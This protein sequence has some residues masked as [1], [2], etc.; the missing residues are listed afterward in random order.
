MKI[1]DF[2]E[3]DNAIQR[4]IELVYVN[5]LIKR[6]PKKTG[7]TA[8]QWTSYSTNNFNYVISNTEGDIIT[9]LE[10][11]TK[12]H[13]IRPITKK[14]LRFEIKKPPVLR[15]PKEQKRFKEK[16]VIFFFNK[17]RQPVLGFSKEGGK[18]FCFAKKV[19]HPGFEGQFFIRD[20]LDDNVLFKK[21]EDK[22]IDSISKL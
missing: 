5:E 16:G 11:G 19:M 9:Y 1:I 6:T 12:A 7:F 10:E 21:F 20:I 17:T 13:T 22:V 3:L 4:A 2:K 15:N 8:S 18:Y 14:M